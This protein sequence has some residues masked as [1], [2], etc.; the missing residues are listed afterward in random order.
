MFYTKSHFIDSRGKTYGSPIESD[1]FENVLHKIT[2]CWLTRRDTWK[3]NRKWSL[4][5]LP[6]RDIWKPSRK[7][8]LWGLRNE[9]YGSPV[10][11]DLFENVLHKITLCWLT[12]RDIWKSNRKWSLWGLPRRDIW[13]CNRK[14]SHFYIRSPHDVVDKHIAM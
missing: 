14:W 5:G 13:K 8:S 3:P 10:E 9:T 1:L 4:W 6:R 11:S 12:R 2:L 7:W